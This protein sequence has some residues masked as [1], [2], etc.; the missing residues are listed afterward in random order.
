M[1]TEKIS[2]PKCYFD[3]NTLI[4]K[5]GNSY[6]GYKELQCIQVTPFTK[7]NKEKESLGNGWYGGL[8]LV[9]KTYD[10]YFAIIEN[11][12][13][14]GIL[15]HPYYQNIKSDI[16]PIN[17]KYHPAEVIEFIKHFNK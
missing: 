1:K 10:K 3:Y 2:F 6:K 15:N 11:G 14:I 17:Y 9:T 12:K 8:I 16:L 7:Q 5:V 4:A 13:I